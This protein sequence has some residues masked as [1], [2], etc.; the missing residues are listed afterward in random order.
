MKM[1]KQTN[2]TFFYQFLG[3]SNQGPVCMLGK[4]PIT[5]IF[6]PSVPQAVFCFQYIEI[7]KKTWFYYIVQTCFKLLAILSQLPKCEDSFTGMRTFSA[8]MYFLTNKYKSALEV[9][10]YFL[11]KKY[12]VTSKALLFETVSYSQKWQQ[13]CYT[14]EDDLELQIILQS[15]LEGQLFLF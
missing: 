11:T 6:I 15:T 7:K 12:I 13:T 1:D 3:G 5:E 9:T 8:T 2:I 4:S 14:V 10:M